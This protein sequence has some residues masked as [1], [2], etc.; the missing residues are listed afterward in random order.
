MTGGFKLYDGATNKWFFNLGVELPENFL[1]D[2]EIIYMYITY[3]DGA[4][5]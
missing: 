4:Q 5:T 2:G 1:S 3:A